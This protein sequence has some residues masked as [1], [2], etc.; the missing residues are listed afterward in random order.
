[1]LFLFATECYEALMATRFNVIALLAVLSLGFVSSRSAVAD[2]DEPQGLYIPGLTISGRQTENGQPVPGAKHYLERCDILM[3][4][5][6]DGVVRIAQVIKSTGHSR[7]DDACLQAAIGQRITPAQTT[8]GP[9]DHWAILPVTWDLAGKNP[10]APDRLD[11][12]IAPMAPNQSLRITAR[13]Y[14]KGAL[15]RAEQGNAWVHV[16]VSDTGAIVDLKI[17]K[18]SGSPE[19]DRATLDAMSIA[20]FS[21]AFIDHKAVNS[22]ADIVIAWK[23]PESNPSST[24]DAQPTH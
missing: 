8:N 9:V 14:P 22:D 20:H 18:S 4:V 11:P 16:D 2:I 19:L 5:T 24:S 12:A 21:P 3:W 15:Q 7:L 1:M 17:T 10:T 23:L 13:D 6:S